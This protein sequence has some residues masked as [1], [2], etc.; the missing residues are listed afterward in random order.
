MPSPKGV[1]EWIGVVAR[2]R[3]RDA[4]LV[5]VIAGR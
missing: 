2:R 1:F 3:L 4:E 5:V